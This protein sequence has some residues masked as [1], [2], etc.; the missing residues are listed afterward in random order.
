[1]QPIGGEGSAEND[2][3]EVVDVLTADRLLAHWLA[4]ARVHTEEAI[5]GPEAREELVWSHGAGS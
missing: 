5:V 2:R 3:E 1:M 4:P